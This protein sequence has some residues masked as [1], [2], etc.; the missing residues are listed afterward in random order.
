MCIG[1]LLGLSIYLFACLFVL[2]AEMREREAKRVFMFRRYCHLLSSFFSV[3]GRLM[4]CECASILCS[5][6]SSNFNDYSFLFP[7]QAHYFTPVTVY[8]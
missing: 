5:H 7:P 8:S 1:I 6:T 2:V 4:K 3:Y